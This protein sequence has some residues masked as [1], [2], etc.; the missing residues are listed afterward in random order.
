MKTI[1]WVIEHYESLETSVDD[2]FARWLLIFL[3][4]AQMLQLA[5][6]K[7]KIANDENAKEHDTEIIEWSRENILD[8]LKRDVEFGWE[9]ACDERGISSGLMHEVVCAWNKILE[10]GLEEFD[11]YNP[12][13]KPTFQ[14]TAKKYGWF[15]P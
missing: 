11:D 7:F 12:Y 1:D 13:G 6:G 15:L 5:N 8:Q 10:E 9:K 2:R 14:A 4:I 3:T